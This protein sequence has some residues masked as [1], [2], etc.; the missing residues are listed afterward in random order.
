MAQGDGTGFVS[1]GADRIEQRQ[2]ALAIADKPGGKGP[3]IEPGRRGHAGNYTGKE[4]LDS[5]A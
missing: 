4:M 2:R 3:A 5:A 1:L